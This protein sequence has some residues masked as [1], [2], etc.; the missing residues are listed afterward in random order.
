MQ[1]D[2]NRFIVALSWLA[3]ALSLLASAGVVFIALFELR[4]QER[5]YPGVTISGISVGGLTRPEAES[6]LQSV[7]AAGHTWW[8]LLR[9][10]GQAWLPTQQELG[11]EFDIADS[12]RRAYAV[13]RSKGLAR[14][15]AEQ[16]AAYRRGAD[17]TPA[18]RFDRAQ[19]RRYLSGLAQLVRVPVRE[20]G[21]RV[22]ETRV[23]MT[24][25]QVGYELDEA[26][27]LQ[28]VEER[29]LAGRGGEVAL[30]VREV[31][32][33]VTDLSGLGAQVERILAGPLEL[34]APANAARRTWTLPPEELAKMLVIQQKVGSDGA[35]TGMA[36]L[37]E[38]A[39]RAR[40]EAI[41]KE[42]DQ[43]A[44][45]GKIDFDMNRKQLVVL[46]P[47]QTGFKLDVAR[48]VQ[49]LQERSLTTERQIP[50]PVSV[51][52]PLIDTNNLAGLGIKDLVIKATTYFKGS[53]V[54]RTK[55]IK[56]AT[57]R[58]DG[59]LTPPSEIFSFNRYL[60]EVTAEEGYSESLII[61]GDRTAVGI[62]GG[63]CQ[64]S[65][66][67]FRAA[68]Y[69]GLEILERT[70]HG[71]RVSW[72]EPPVGMDATVFSPVV[73]FKFRNDTAGY[74]L[75]KTEINDDAG[76]LTFYFYGTPT[77]RVV[78]MQGPTETNVTAPDPPE[79]RDDPTLPAGV[80]KQVEWARDGVDITVKR[81]VKLD[82]KV[83]RQD[84][85]LSNYQPWRAVYLVGKK[86]G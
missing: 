65:T 53:S 11:A 66:T 51:V 69:A 38:K 15:L 30:V 83:I 81:I 80:T 32:P 64:V 24:S 23:E 77:G 33:V 62:G 76:S 2:G 68:F 43:G 46:S 16:W 25:S 58:F 52:N 72:Y 31:R 7:F 26:A 57:A 63:I 8:P 4:Y 3:L 9:Y 27:T 5:I 10:G 56:L 22:V 14:A 29:I 40:V 74:L 61:W 18:I 37:S 6:I 50:M 44:I 21:L 34:V 48:T 82:G 41:A 35:I 85:F 36:A 84:T 55:N 28:E 54:E 79:Y 86:S 78:E 47:S 75:M 73:D 60:G 39:L 17:L 71:Y 59:V 20:A 12:V 70:A 49:L 42:L 13:G 1:K 67:A 19:A 45:E